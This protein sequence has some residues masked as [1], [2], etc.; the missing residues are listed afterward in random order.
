MELGM[1][2]A[3]LGIVLLIPVGIAIFLFIQ[4]SKSKSGRRPMMM[5]ASG[6]DDEPQ[7]I[8]KLLSGQQGPK[9]APK[10][11]LKI[12][13]LNDRLQS[14]SYSLQK[15]TEGQSSALS[16]N[17]K[18]EFARR[19]GQELAAD[20][21]PTQLEAIAKAEEKWAKVRAKGQKA[22]DEMAAKKRLAAVGK[23][24]PVGTNKE[25]KKKGFM[26]KMKGSNELE[27]A[28]ATMMDGE[29]QY[30]EAVSKVL[31]PEQRVAL[32]KLLKDSPQGWQSG[33]DILALPPH[34]K[35]TATAKKVFVLKFFG[36]VQAAQVKQLR[37]EVTAI[38]TS[39]NAERGDEVVLILNSGGGTVTGY[40]LSASQL[41]RLKARGLKL[42]ICVEEVAASGG[43]MMACT[44][45]RLVASPFAVLGSIGVIS[46][47]PNVFERL[48]RE[49]VVFN[50]TTAGEFKRTLTPFKET[51]EEDKAKLKEDIEA[52]LV[53]FK[54]FVSKNRPK[55][56]IDKVATGETWFGA[57]A[58]E[59]SLC[60][61][62]KTS[63]D[64]LLE[65]LDQGAELFSVA[66]KPPSSP[67]ASLAP[68]ASALGNVAPTSDLRGYL[69]RVLLGLETNATMQ[70]P[71]VQQ[72]PYQLQDVGPTPMAQDPAFYRQENEWDTF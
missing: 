63:D 48:K 32:Q 27:S 43:Y 25:E 69:L 20:L 57:D 45:D 64:V 62:L 4:F 55:L 53:L 2:S 47:Q 33:E 42:T 51:T 36:N 8:F 12:E 41:M 66:I 30:I 59:R 58:L 14:Y 7:G 10:E 70:L 3:K 22:I 28:Y 13:R 21:T 11:Y 26:P 1:F 34:E 68:A 54:D 50:T 17:R 38:L 23:A 24:G 31:N 67:L 9:G 19:F 6:E 46:E 5:M 44:A 29:L 65:Y 15:A 37:Q 61:E 40:G 35:D 18:V 60:D 72:S 16:S 49:G 39:A 52:I 71:Q 56:D